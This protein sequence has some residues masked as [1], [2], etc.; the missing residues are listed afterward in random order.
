MKLGE[1]DFQAEFR[2]DGWLVAD[3]GDELE[4]V[5]SLARELGSKTV[6][7]F[8]VCG[9]LDND[10]HHQIYLIPRG[11]LSDV[12]EGFNTQMSL[13]MLGKVDALV[14]VVPYY[15]DPRGFKFTFGETVDRK[16]G[17]KILDC[18]DTV[19]VMAMC[20][21]DFLSEEIDDASSDP[22]ETI[23]DFIV[24]KQRVELYWEFWA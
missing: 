14:P 13:V 24:S 19:A 5:E 17:K 3:A 23:L 22:S 9:W 2:K 11:S 1:I 20:E 21:V 16:M 8:S 18:L 6:D 12:T 15:A 10:E 7:H 4:M